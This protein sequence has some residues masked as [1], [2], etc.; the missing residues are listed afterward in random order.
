MED[1]YLVETWI[2]HMESTPLLSLDIHKVLTHVHW[3]LC[4]VTDEG[5]CHLL[6][7][8]YMY[9]LKEMSILHMYGM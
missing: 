4:F 9:C 5:T 2:V 8:I 3:Q 6:L 7:L 1:G